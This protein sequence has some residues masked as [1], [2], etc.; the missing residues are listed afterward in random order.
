MRCPRFQAPDSAMGLHS[1]FQAR[2]ALVRLA[3]CCR[4]FRRQDG[5]AGLQN[6]LRQERKDRG[7]RD[8]RRCQGRRL[9]FAGA[10]VQ[11][12]RIA[13]HCDSRLGIVD[14]AE[15]GFLVN[16]RVIATTGFLG[17][18][19]PGCAGNRWSSRPRS[20]AS[21]SASS[22]FL[23]DGRPRVEVERLRLIDPFLRRGR[24]PR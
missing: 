9:V 4:R 16:H 12:C 18:W 7:H 24:G 19:R 6:Q 3:R 11:S 5:D 8:V 14:G 1:S 2:E 22:S 21:L 10:A 15:P 13:T 17:G 23:P 20:Q